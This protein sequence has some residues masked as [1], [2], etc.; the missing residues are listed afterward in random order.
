[1]VVSLASVSRIGP[2]ARAACAAAFVGSLAIAPAAQPSRAAPAEAAQ[3]A[4]FLPVALIGRFGPAPVPIPRPSATPT[5]A[6]TAAPT[7]VPSPTAPATP[8]PGTA[9]PTAPS[10]PPPTAAPSPGGPTATAEP[11]A[12]TPERRS[13]QSRVSGSVYAVIETDW[14]MA[15]PDITIR[16]VSL[17]DGTDVARTATDLYGMFHLPPQPA[18]TYGLCWEG[19][20]FPGE[21]VAAPV[22]VADEDVTVQPIAIHPEPGVIYGRVTLREGEACHLFDPA[23]NVHV[24]TVVE[25]QTSDGTPIGAPVR[26]SMAGEYI[27]AGQP[28]T[29]RFRLQARCGASVV[30]AGLTDPGDTPQ[31]I[32]MVF[33]NARPILDGIEARADGRGVRVAAPGAAVDV[34]ALASDANGDPLTYDWTVSPGAG[35]LVSTEGA[36]ARWRLPEVEGVHDLNLVVADGRGGFARGTVHLEV[37]AG[38]GARFAGLVLDAETGAPLTGATVRV[39]TGDAVVDAPVESG[40]RYALE[41][42]GAAEDEAIVYVHRAGYAPRVLV[43]DGEAQGAAFRLAPLE[44]QA[45]DPAAATT[46]V[47]RR[48]AVI[49]ARQP[50]ARVELPPDSLIGVTDGVRPTGM[51]TGTIG[52]PIIG[53]GD[54]G[55]GLPFP[56]DTMQQGRALGLDREGTPRHLD[57]YGTVSIAFH[58]AAERAYAPRPGTRLGFT[59]PISAALAISAP[60]S[61]PIW[62]LDGATG[63]WWD[64]HGRADLVETPDGPMYV[65]A[66]DVPESTASPTSLVEQLYQIA[67][68]DGF[69]LTCVRV[70]PDAT[71]RPGTTLRAEVRYGNATLA[72]YQQPIVLGQ[73]YYPFLQIQKASALRLLLLDTKGRLIATATKT[74]PLGT[75]PLIPGEGTAGIPAPYSACGAPVP[76]TIP[77]PT[78]IAKD[79]SGEMFLTGLGYVDYAS[80]SVTSGDVTAAYYAAVDPFNQRTTLSQWWQLNGFGVKG[81]APGGAGEL[82]AAYVNA[83]DLGFGRDMHCLQT[84]PKVACWVTNY[85][86]PNFGP[87][88]GY[89]YPGNADLAAGHLGPGKT[90]T[91]EYTDVPAEPGRRFVTF[92]AFDGGTGSAPRLDA[93]DLDQS[94]AKPIPQLCAVC[95]GGRYDPQGPTSGPFDPLSPTVDDLDFGASF[96]EW[97]LPSLRYALGRDETQLTPAE[98][99]TFR[100][101]NERVRDHTA[102]SAAIVELLDGWYGPSGNPH[103]APAPDLSFVPPGFVGAAQEGLYRDVIA[104]SCRTCHIARSSGIDFNAYVGDL[105]GWS[106]AIADRVCGPNK[107]MPNAKLTFNNFWWSTNPHRPAS[108]AAWD[109]GAVWTPAIGSCP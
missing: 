99:N 19:P 8:P 61:A 74:V 41:A 50:G 104:P 13:R 2:F 109:D 87:D 11:P 78:D 28:T 23:R 40:G 16:L 33:D 70:A 89:V 26:S 79:A 56:D 12:P 22:T 67:L 35:T 39:A 51:V 107:I 81:D 90:V 58:D 72:A 88:T 45:V 59:V 15:V 31:R 76:L 47:D 98:L 6:S 64:T 38:G 49:R 14:R 108:L 85:G 30:E 20:G 57:A 24:W 48:P 52:G 10:T 93:V 29:G 37:R 7:G 21:C 96:R 44:G 69:N 43:R 94:Y 97:D 42:R 32:D 3:G 25:L 84:G 65:G 75:R 106:G 66:A 103:V 73:T 46:L 77:L 71:V 1:M 83:N 5:V 4:I 27:R 34:I 54:G 53:G 17:A 68:P 62:F 102:P 105:D 36:L 63:M 91:M 9:S 86:V 18:G 82:K 55:G 101:L 95:H 60:T 80:L 100:G 92:Y